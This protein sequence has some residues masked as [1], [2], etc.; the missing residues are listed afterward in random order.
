MPAQ[1]PSQVQ[2]FMTPWTVA[3]QASLS[4]EFPRQEDWSGWPFPTP[5]NLPGVEPMSLA[6][7]ALTGGIFL[8]L[9]PVKGTL[10]DSSHLQMTSVYGRYCFLIHTFTILPFFSRES[11]LCLELQCT[12]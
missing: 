7:P 5:G 6:S 3:H 4:M 11:F 10:S 8:T 9:F 2:L 12:R 1:S